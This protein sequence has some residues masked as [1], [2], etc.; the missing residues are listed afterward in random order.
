MSGRKGDEEYSKVLESAKS[1]I[2]KFK[3]AYFI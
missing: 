2:I 3:D 1:I